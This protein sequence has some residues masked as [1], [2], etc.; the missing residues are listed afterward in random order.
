M[1]HRK[2]FC[3]ASVSA[4]PLPEWLFALSDY[5]LSELMHGAQNHV[6]ESIADEV[7]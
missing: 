6:A 5:A 7:E 4:L 3:A 2:S 1:L